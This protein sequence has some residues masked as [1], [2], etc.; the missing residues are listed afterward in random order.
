MPQG[1][2]FIGR[3]PGGEPAWRFPAD[4]P[5]D[6][7]LAACVACGLCLPHCPTYRITGE[8]SASPRGRIAAMRAVHFGGQ[9]IDD[10]FTEFMDLCVQ[11]RGCEAA[12]PSS[13]PFGHLME[14]ARETLAEQTPY[15]PWWKRLGYRVLGY[16][17]LLLGLSTLLAVAQRMHLIPKR[18]AT[19]LPPL[20]LRRERLVATGTDAWLFTGCVM[21]AW[22]R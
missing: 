11:C 22:Q 13:V 6:T 8:E 19:G 1:V 18:V 9:P 21:D 12:C 17:W 20:P 2:R 15:Q 7:D 3:L 16:H 10:S 14:G 4:A 5:G